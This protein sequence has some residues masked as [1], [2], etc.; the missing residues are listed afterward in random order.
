MDAVIS[1]KLNRQYS[2]IENQKQ[3]NTNSKFSKW[4]KNGGKTDTIVF[5]SENFR[6]RRVFFR[7][8][9]LTVKKKKKNPP[10][11]QINTN[12]FYLK[13]LLSVRIWLRNLS[14]DF[15]PRVDSFEK[16]SA[17]RNCIIALA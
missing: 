4:L 10:T 15:L 2:F 16:P 6:L 7:R 13:I 5:T 17:Q 8:Q 9:C 3:K 12:N 11:V 1:N 14:A